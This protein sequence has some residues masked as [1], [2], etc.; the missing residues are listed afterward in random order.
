MNWGTRIRTGDL[1]TVAALAIVSLIVSATFALDLR[2]LGELSHTNQAQFHLSL[3]NA[4]S[5]STYTYAFSASLVPNAWSDEAVRL[6]ET[7]QMLFVFSMTN[8][9]AAFFRARESS[10]EDFDGDELSNI[11]EF[12]YGAD[13]EDVDSDDDGMWDGWEVQKGFSPT[14]AADGREDRDGDEAENFKEFLFQADPDVA[15][16]DVDGMQDGW[17]I[18]YGLN[19]TNN[20]AAGDLD[21]DGLLNLDEYKRSTDPADPD[22]DNDGISDGPSAVGAIF[23]GPDPNPLSPAPG[24]LPLFH[25]AEPGKTIA[26]TEDSR[27]RPLVAWKAPDAQGN[28]QVY[29]MQWFG[30]ASDVAG[31]WA[32][33]NGT[34]ECF[35]SSASGSGVTLATNDVRR[36]DLAV[37]TNGWPAVCWSQALG[38]T[39]AIYYLAWD[40]TN[41][42]G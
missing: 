16:S 32:E 10:E 3:Q 15:D 7:N 23:A 6:G 41:W 30:L 14:N 5:T 20:D 13:A 8:R 2:V 31:A 34:W 26:L 35:G 18:R 21:S 37:D 27:G 25:I 42:A 29:V 9:I 28:Q 12:E 38:Y 22:S 33:L 24:N 36:F 19:P 11:Q 17:E 1:L 39:G 4:F 40:G